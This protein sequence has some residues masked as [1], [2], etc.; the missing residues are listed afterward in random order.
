MISATLLL[1]ACGGGNSVSFSD[2]DQ[3]SVGNYNVKWSDAS[4]FGRAP[5][6]LTPLMFIITPKDT[7]NGQPASLA[8]RQQLAQAALATSGRCEWVRF[9]PALNARNSSMAGAAEHTL[10]ALARC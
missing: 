6:G 2:R 7:T 10:Y 9:D 5:S 1:A 4:A 3:A 8:Q